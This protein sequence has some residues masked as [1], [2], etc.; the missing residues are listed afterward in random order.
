M[1]MR[2]TPRINY[3]AIAHLYDGQPFLGKTVDPELV[4]FM[5]NAPVQI[6]HLSWIL[7]AGPEASLWQITRL[8][9]MP[10]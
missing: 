3:D 9:P 7:P 1:T 10:C 5:R 4:T 2:T 6:A 8:F